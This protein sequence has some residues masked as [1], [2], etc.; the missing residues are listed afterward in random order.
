MSENSSYKPVE[1]ALRVLQI[2][3]ILA[4]HEFIG[5]TPGE[6]AKATGSSPSQVGHYLVTLE[7]AGFAERV[8]DT[9]NWRLGPAL[10]RIGL[11]F[12]RHLSAQEQKLAEI[13]NRFTR[14]V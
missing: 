4:G 13:T 7:A 1:S 12:M 10:P 14:D 6:I 5:K 11:A 8:P 9:G 2:I 3:P